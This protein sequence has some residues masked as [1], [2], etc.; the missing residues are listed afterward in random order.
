MS[1]AFYREWRPQIWDDVVGQDQVVQT[2]RNAVRAE[3][4]VHA[5]LFAGPR[6][7]GKTSS[8]RLLAKAVNCLAEDPGSRP[9]NT[10]DYCLALQE[11]R[12]LDL[13]EID[14]ASNTSVDDVRDLRDKINFSPNQ[15][16]YKVYIIDEVHMLSTAAFNALLKTLE[17]P[18]DHAIFILATTEIH[19]I[20]A[21]VLSR[22]Q[23]H[24]FRR[25]PVGVMLAYLQRK[26]AAE[27]L[28]VE[29]AVLDIIARQATG[30]LRDAISL[31][32]QLV[33]TGERVTLDAA[34]E[35]LGT[36][37]SEAVRRVVQARFAG[38]RSEGLRLILE[39]MDRGADPRQFARQIMDY[40]HILLLH[41]MQNRDLGDVGPDERAEIE[42][43]AAAVAVPEILFV[44]EAFNKA[45]YEQGGS[46]IPSL[47][48]ELAFLSESFAGSG[49]EDLGVVRASGTAAPVMAVTTEQESGQVEIH[50]AQAEAAPMS[51]AEEIK[52]PQVPVQAQSEPIDEADTGSKPG[53]STTFSQIE[54]QWQETLQEVRRRDPILQGLLN[55]SKPLAMEAGALV[56]G[57]ESDLLR[58]KMLKPDHLQVIQDALQA[59]FAVQMTIRCV[60]RSEWVSVSQGQAAHHPVEDGGI[61]AEAI[62]RFGAHVVDVEDLKAGPD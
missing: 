4:V 54:S 32:D 48:L 38:E 36:A 53:G 62:N 9:C 7:T 22:C 14:A 13:I 2:L 17:E 25:I 37:T 16:R 44:I 58:E 27:S 12:F 8:A 39:A 57:F 3:R 46:H 29:P 47:A 23:R 26:V 56:L 60:L 11:G 43:I 1:Q 40:L 51:R 19:K 30:S 59:V 35:I 20:P 49:S 33:S 55:S 15:G 42:R 10:C 5:Y 18:P 50:S 34:R 28:L 45:G 24:E 31:L 21:T 61:V 52:A 6:G 41:K